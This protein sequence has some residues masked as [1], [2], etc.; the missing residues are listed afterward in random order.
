MVYFRIQGDGGRWAFKNRRINLWVVN[1]SVLIS[2]LSINALLFG[3][4]ALPLV[5]QVSACLGLCITL[6]PQLSTSA[7]RWSLGLSVLRPPAVCSVQ[8]CFFCL[9]FMVSP[10]TVLAS[11]EI[12]DSFVILCASCTFCQI[13]VSPFFYFMPL[14]APLVCSQS[15][16]NHGVNTSGIIMNI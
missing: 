6:L 7:V 4:S 12:A 10:K 2:M 9:L 8:V 5:L 1:L 15:I 16:Q 11:S 14:C 3:H 13:S